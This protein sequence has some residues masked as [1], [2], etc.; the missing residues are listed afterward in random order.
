M[1]STDVVV[2]ATS[3]RKTLMR[4]MADYTNSGSIGKGVKGGWFAIHIKDINT[5]YLGETKSFKEM[6]ARLYKG[7]GSDTNAIATC[8]KDAIHRG[9][10]LGVWLLTQPERF[11]IEKLKEQLI[12]MDVLEGRK[13]RVF[14][15]GGKLYSIRHSATNDYFIVV[16]RANYAPGGLLGN[17]L[18]RLNSL[19]NTGYNTLL[20]EF[21][22]EQA[23]DIIKGI[24]FTITEIGSFEDEETRQK[25]QADFI[26]QNKF[27][28]NMNYIGRS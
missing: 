6:K 8:L 3:V 13:K 2:D 16:D 20:K 19:G 15:G 22:T 7:N 21:V 24:G 23:N 28:R 26:Q 27:G 12:E 14:T 11:D 10:E 5:V 9:A 18:I 4:F 25:L 17:F 1:Q